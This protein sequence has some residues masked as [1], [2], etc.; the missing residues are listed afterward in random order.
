MGGLER[1]GMHQPSPLGKKAKI[2]IV[3]VLTTRSVFRMHDFRTHDHQM[4]DQ[5]CAI[6][7]QT[8]NSKVMDVET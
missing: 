4:C 1:P 8:M 6:I 2:N 7:Q 3:P 5:S